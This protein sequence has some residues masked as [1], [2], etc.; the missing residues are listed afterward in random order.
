[1]TTAVETGLKYTS[2]TAAAA[3]LQW[4]LVYTC[5]EPWW[6]S[7]IGRSLVANALLAATTPLVFILALWFNISR[8]TS[9]VLGWI[10]VGVFV[11]TTLLLSWRSV[12]WVRA[13]RGKLLPP[14]PP[15]G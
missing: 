9:Q 10:E 12:I 7:R 1:M 15:P 3:L 11:F 13:S 5:L 8:L 4:V 6:K 14:P 2:I